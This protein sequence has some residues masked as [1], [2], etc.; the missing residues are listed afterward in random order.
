M[1]A[2]AAQAEE[3]RAVGIASICFLP[4]LHAAHLGF[5]ARLLK[6]KRGCGVVRLPDKLRNGRLRALRV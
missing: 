2:V 5:S 1:L 3:H 6:M 4:R